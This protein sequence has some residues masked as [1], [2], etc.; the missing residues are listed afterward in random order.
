M[1]ISVGEVINSIKEDKKLRKQGR[2]EKIYF[3]ASFFSLLVLIIGLGGNISVD[4]KIII[5]I[6]GII[7]LFYFVSKYNK[8]SSNRIKHFKTNYIQKILSENFE[9]IQYKYDESISI[10]DYFNSGIFRKL[11]NC[12]YNGNDYMKKSNIKYET[13]MSYIEV[14]YAERSRRVTQFSGYF[15]KNEIKRKTKNE[16]SFII[17][18]KETIWVKGILAILFALIINFFLFIVGG[19]IV[20]YVIPQVKEHNLTRLDLIAFFSISLILSIM[21]MRK[22]YQ[23]KNLLLNSKFDKIYK[24]EGN[25]EHLKEIFKESLVSNIFAFRKKYKAEVYISKIEDKIY[26]AIKTYKKIPEGLTQEEK[27]LILERFL[28]LQG[29]LELNDLICKEILDCNLEEKN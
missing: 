22:Y 14:T 6:T 1:K 5:S 21:L 15:I 11:N 24:Y 4:Y 16:D 3:L 8:I 17:E 2:L 28:V 23:S 10:E 13:E 20:I 7:A 19:V 18:P 25:S 26:L 27:N 12:E 9:N 29:A